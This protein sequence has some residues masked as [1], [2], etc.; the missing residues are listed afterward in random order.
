[1]TEKEGEKLRRL[2]YRTSF[3]DLIIIFVLSERDS[4]GAVLCDEG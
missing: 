3:R 4:T 2:I 1:M